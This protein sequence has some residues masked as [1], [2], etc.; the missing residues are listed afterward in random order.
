MVDVIIPTV[1]MRKLRHREQNFPGLCDSEAQSTPTSELG[2]CWSQ[3]PHPPPSVRTFHWVHRLTLSSPST[4]VQSP[5]PSSAQD[6]RHLQDFPSGWESG[7]VLELLR[8]WPRDQT[9]FWP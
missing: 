8:S 4:S 5:D 6:L 9:H 3:W 2:V 7:P 1:Q